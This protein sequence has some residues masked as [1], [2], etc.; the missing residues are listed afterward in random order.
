[1][2]RRIDR[3][4]TFK[5]G[6]DYDFDNGFTKEWR[7]GLEMEKKC[8]SYALRYKENV[9]PSLT[10]G[11][12]ESIKTRGIYLQVRFAHIGGVEY[13]YIK[14]SASDGYYNR[15]SSDMLPAEPASF[16]MQ[17]RYSEE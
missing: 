14:D 7:L 10:S 17:R 4:Y 12:T 6:I 5:G 13:K 2:S 1:M 15:P 11:G 3:R 8:W 9:T 16:N